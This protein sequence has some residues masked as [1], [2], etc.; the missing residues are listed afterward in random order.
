MNK[1]SD[2]TRFRREEYKVFM[3]ELIND[4]S[5]MAEIENQINER[6]SQIENQNS[7]EFMTAL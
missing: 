2:K 4:Q 7:L 6:Y 3:Q 5:R 1:Q